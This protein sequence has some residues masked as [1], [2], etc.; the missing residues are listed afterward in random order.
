[1]TAHCDGLPGSEIRKDRRQ[2]DADIAFRLWHGQWARLP[3]G[4]DLR[5]DGVGHRPLTE[6]SAPNADTATP[7]RY[8]P[9]DV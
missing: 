8:G 7:A 6:T 3:N 1:M 9:A 5:A 4:W 2:V